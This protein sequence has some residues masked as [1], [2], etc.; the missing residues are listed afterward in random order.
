MKS[1][2]CKNCSYYTAYYRKWSSSFEKLTH[3]ACSK[4]KSP[5][6]QSEVCDDF[7]SSE[8]KERKREERLF[9]SLEQSLESINQ[10]AQILKEKYS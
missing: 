7:K 8:Q 3:G 6:T 5:K 9:I 1:Q 10:I 2:K 4:H